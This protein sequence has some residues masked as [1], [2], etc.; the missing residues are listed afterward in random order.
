M[1]N[2]I[3]VLASL[4]TAF[5]FSTASGDIHDA[6]AAKTAAIKLAKAMDVI[7]IKCAE[8]RLLGVH[9][10]ADKVGDLA[11]SLDDELNDVELI[12]NMNKIRETFRELHGAYL[13]LRTTI[14]HV[15]DP[16][17]RKEILAGTLADFEELS[18]SIYGERKTKT[19]VPS[20]I[21][22]KAGDAKSN[23]QDDIQDR[24]RTDYPLF[25]S[26]LD[27]GSYSKPRKIEPST[28]K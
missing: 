21:D 13:N 16:T 1:K 24:D 22:N 23:R 20:E 17:F 10:W 12:N 9:F 8:K 27:G 19:V 18:D 26:E 28:T 25:D 14:R 15:S 3:T 7:E 5:G 11:K 6:K 4:F 2:L